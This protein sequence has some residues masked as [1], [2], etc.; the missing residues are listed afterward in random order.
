MAGSRLQLAFWC[1]KARDLQLPSAGKHR[2]AKGRKEQPCR[3]GAAHAAGFLLATLINY[4]DLSAQEA[5][6]DKMQGAI[7]S[8]RLR[9]IPQ[10]PAGARGCLQSLAGEPLLPLA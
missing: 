2:A 8:Y 6:D 7:L 5:D 4:T 3:Q 10:F 9:G 1:G